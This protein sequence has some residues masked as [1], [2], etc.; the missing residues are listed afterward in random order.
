MISDIPDLVN[1]L[2]E[3]AGGAFLFLNVLA[4]LRDKKLRGVHWLPT[5][6]FNSWGIWN[7]FYYHHLDQPLSWYGGLVIVSV[8]TWWLYL[9]GYYKLKEVANE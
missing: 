3:L 2:F 5:V 6:F 1:G 9:I 8:N 4:L 7:L